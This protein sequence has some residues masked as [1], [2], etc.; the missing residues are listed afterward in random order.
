MCDG[1]IAGPL[2]WG[3]LHCV[4]DERI[5]WPLPGTLSLQAYYSLSETLMLTVVLRCVFCFRKATCTPNAMS[6]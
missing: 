6:Q 2:Q 5:H 4:L 1:L 3:N